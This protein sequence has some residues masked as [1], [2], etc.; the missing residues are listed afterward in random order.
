[1]ALKAQKLTDAE[2][3]AAMQTLREQQQTRM[4]SV[5]TPAQKEQWEKMKANRNEGMREGK[6][7]KGDSTM[8]HKGDGRSGKAGVKL[9]KQLNLTAAQQTKMKALRTDY[10]AKA[11]ALR[12]DQA[13]SNE[14]KSAKMQVL[15]KQ[16]HEQVKSVLT[17]EQQQ[18]LKSLRAERK[19]PVTR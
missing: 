4:Q 1:E 15:R 12:N 19:T 18:K 16:Q 13:L 9:Q 3:K 5:L 2:R 6:G 14:Q 11:D 7:W 10:K 17:K 8:H